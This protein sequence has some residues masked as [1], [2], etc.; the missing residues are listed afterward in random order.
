MNIFYYRRFI[1]E[2]KKKNYQKAVQYLEKGILAGDER[3]FIYRAFYY[4]LGLVEKENR[5]MANRLVAP[6]LDSIIEKAQKGD[7]EYAYFLGF[8]Y[9]LPLGF[10]H[11]S[12]SKR[13]FWYTKSAESG[14]VFS[15]Y[16]LGWF[17]YD[18]SGSKENNIKALYW[19][20]EAAKQGLIAAQIDVAGIYS[21]GENIEKDAKKAIFWLEKAAKYNNAEAF[22]HLSDIYYQGDGVEKDLK[23]AI[24]LAMK[25]AKLGS[26]SAQYNLGYLY[27]SGE[28]VEK[29]DLLAV[30]WWNKSA[31]Q[32]YEMAQSNLAICYQDGDGVEKNA[33]LSFYWAKK[34][35]IQGNATSQYNLGNF[36]R[37]GIVIK[38]NYER[39]VYWWTK[40]AE[41]G[42]VSAQYNLGF[43][44]RDGR[45]VEKDVSKAVSWWI[46][47][48]EAGDLAAQ[49]NVGV[50]YENG[51][52]VERDMQEAIYWYREAA[53]QGNALAQ[54]NLS[55]VHYDGN[56]LNKDIEA[57][58]LMLSKAAEQGL[59]EAQ[60]R[61]GAH[62]EN[63][64]NPD[65]DLEKAISWWT[66]AAEQGDQ[67]AQYGL[68]VLY[69]YGIDIPVDIPKAVHFY[70]L[71]AENGDSN[72]QYQLAIIYQF[73]EGVEKNI[74]KAISLLTKAA[75][76]DS[77]DAQVRLGELILEE[78]SYSP[79]RGLKWLRI[80]VGQGNG[81]A[82]YALGMAY[83][84]GV[85]GS[86]DYEKAQYHLQKANELGVTNSGI[87]EILNGLLSESVSNKTM[88]KYSLEFKENLDSLAINRKINRDLASDFL[89]NWAYLHPDTKLLLN[90]GYTDY[91]K[92]KRL[93]NIDNKSDYSKVV[94]QIT[95]ALENEL[96]VHLNQRY[97]QFIIQN[98]LSPYNFSDDEKKYLFENNEEGQYFLNVDKVAQ[99]FKLEKIAII[100]GMKTE[101]IALNQEDELGLSRPF[102]FSQ[103]TIDG[104][105]L[106][107]V[108]M[109]TGEINK[110]TVSARK[111]VY[112][113][114]FNPHFMR[115]ADSLFK[116]TAF[117][118]GN[119]QEEMVAYLID[120]RRQI[121]EIAS[122]YHNKATSQ[123]PLSQIEAEICAEWIIKTK[124]LLP[125]FL[126]K[127]KPQFLV[128]DLAKAKRRN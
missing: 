48:A 62:Y 28:G 114:T 10:A 50:H 106:N 98:N 15:Q 5:K 94:W 51:D 39:S 22:S 4:A 45:G 19:L 121:L 123:Q 25:A 68:G 60:Y 13:F 120:F 18:E 124:K 112:K 3:A 2:D 107:E 53:R 75:N 82:H 65:R 16:R 59:V 44:Y 86:I 20:T 101:P 84:T 103:K 92:Q 122:L 78:K 34:A 93:D 8:M 128:E 1:S 11:K 95:E 52:G 116:E 63:E 57:G 66:K 83:W 41:Q 110:K 32:G 79:E 96:N 26:A 17:L 126:N 43:A 74:K 100:M 115:F 35:A 90:A 76:N 117:S 61:L 125:I 33:K 105:A 30:Y 109:L 119:R 46:K 58:F 6:F 91:I 80:A 113:T 88:E 23:K 40:A 64:M 111:H 102:M 38:R 54:Y 55:R 89:E 87:L 49:N 118:R 7:A 97:L 81:S 12:K 14:F 99:S 127:I 77:E 27:Y 67:R 29:D 24:N 37:D 56:E 70:G 9:G 42:E 72:S 85:A 47:A 69:Q 36:Y 108:S 71:A 31:E 73:G 21:E 104:L